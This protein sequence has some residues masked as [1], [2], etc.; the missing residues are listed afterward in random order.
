MTYTLTGLGDFDDIVGYI[1][2][3]PQSSIMKGLSG[4]YNFTREATCLEPDCIRPM[5]KSISSLS[6]YTDSF[7]KMERLYGDIILKAGANMDIRVSKTENSSIIVFSAIDGSGL[8]DKCECAVNDEMI[9]ITSI[10]GITADENG[11]I[12]VS[13][14]PDENGNVNISG[15]DCLSITADAHGIVLQ[16]TCS[17]PCC[18]CAELDAIYDNLKDCIDGAA[19]L[20]NAVENLVAK[21]EQVEMVYLSEGKESCHCVT[22]NSSSNS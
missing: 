15:S 6:V 10:N 16:D 7:S 20:K 4:Y 8:T 13:G 12:T 3:N 14:V 11:A 9:P 22:N 2:I 1:A 17:E 21:Q 19:T 18:G 5:I